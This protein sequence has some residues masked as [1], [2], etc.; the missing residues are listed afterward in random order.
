MT[1]SPSQQFR[2]AVVCLGN[3]CRSP[4]AESVLR[5]TVDQAGLSERISV[6][7]AGTSGWHAGSDADHR[8]RKALS[9]AGYSAD[10][11]ARLFDSA[12]LSHLDLV[13]GMDYQNVLDLRALTSDPVEI[14]RI[15]LYR[16]FDPVL[17]HLPEGDPA[18]EVPDPYYGTQADFVQVVEMVENATTGII[19]YACLELG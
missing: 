18:L 3:I 17:M 11:T 9:T 5:R 7:S 15:R 2:I 1:D 4:I 12:W 8:A 13:L 14:E 6:E 10:H 19:D 16:S